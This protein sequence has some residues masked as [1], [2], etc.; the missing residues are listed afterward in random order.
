MYR[1][2]SFER[3]RQRY[4]LAGDLIPGGVNTSL[5]RFHPVLRQYQNRLKII[6]FSPHELRYSSACSRSHLP[7]SVFFSR[8]VMSGKSPW[9]TLPFVSSWR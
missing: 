4:A 5:R 3:S 9:R 6:E 1:I 2:H 8:H 7:Y